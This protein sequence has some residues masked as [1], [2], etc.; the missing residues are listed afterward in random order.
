M[1]KITLKDETQTKEAMTITESQ[2]RPMEDGVSSQ[3]SK[4]LRR[5]LVKIQWDFKLRRKC[6]VANT[7]SLGQ[8]TCKLLH[9]ITFNI[10]SSANLDN[11]SRYTPTTNLL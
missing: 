7:K 11:V 9:V 10:I 5:K 1:Q 4:V 8:A 6:T 2:Q 3:I